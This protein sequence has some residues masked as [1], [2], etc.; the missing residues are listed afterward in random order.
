MTVG[1][2]RIQSLWR[3]YIYKKALP[4]ALS[5]DRY[6]KIKELSKKL[7][8]GELMKEIS[9]LVGGKGGGRPDMAQGG[10][11]NIQA[12]QKSLEKVQN[13]VASKL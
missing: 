11:P 10:G 9:A 1:I 13:W 7:P 8:A 3:G 12:L 2:V 5:Q 6:R 4:L